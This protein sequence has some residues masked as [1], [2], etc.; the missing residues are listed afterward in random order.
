MFELCRLSSK[1]DRT[2]TF[3]PLIIVC[4]P[5]NNLLNTLWRYSYLSS[6]YIIDLNLP[7][8]FTFCVL[9]CNDKTVE[10]NFTNFKKLLPL[11]PKY[12]LS[13]TIGCWLNILKEF[14]RN[15][16]RESQNFSEQNR[17]SRDSQKSRGDRCWHAQKKIYFSRF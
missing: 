17:I 16:L 13:T 14:Q 7:A 1:I 4:Y 2:M 6:V 12:L 8:G 5:K 11:D 10:R 9:A 15:L 3:L